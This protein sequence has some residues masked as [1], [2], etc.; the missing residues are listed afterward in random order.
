MAV[1]A[2]RGVARSTYLPEGWV[3]SLNPLLRLTRPVLDAYARAV[4]DPRWQGHYEFILPTVAKRAGLRVEDLGGEGSFVPPGRE[5]SVYVGK[6][7]HGRPPDL[8]FGFRPPRHDYFH[9]KPE[10]FPQHGMLYHPVKPGVPAWTRETRNLNERARPGL[11]ARSLAVPPQV[12]PQHPPELLRRRSV[13][14]V[15]ALTEHVEE[16]LRA[17]LEARRLQHEVDQQARRLGAVPGA[18]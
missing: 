1:V 13:H 15:P 16:R 14:G 4:A 12:G 3:R 8:T 9:E 5:R 17:R 10:T 18:G 7:P 6:S 11:G 2:H